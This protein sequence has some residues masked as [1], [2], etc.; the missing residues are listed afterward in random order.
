MTTLFDTLT[1]NRYTE[2]KHV[3]T[4]QTGDIS[5]SSFEQSEADIYSGPFEK[6]ELFQIKKWLDRLFSYQ[7]YHPAN[8]Y[9][10]HKTVPS[11]RNIHPVVPFITYRGYTFRYD[12]LSGN[13]FRMG[14]AP[15]TNKAELTIALDIGR[16]CKVYGTFGLA[17]ALM[18]MGHVA[19]EALI[20]CGKHNMDASLSYRFYRRHFRTMYQLPADL[21]MGCRIHINLKNSGKE[22]AVGS[23]KPSRLHK[24]YSYVEE[25]RL[26]GLEDWLLHLDQ[27]EPEQMMK[28]LIPASLTLASSFLRGSA[29]T[30]EGLVDIGISIE[31]SWLD[32]FLLLC[33][34]LLSSRQLCNSFSIYLF[35]NHQQNVRNGC[36]KVSSK[37]VGFQA[38]H[39]KGDDFLYDSQ[40]FFNLEQSA[41]SCLFTY[42]KGE[43]KSEYEH[44]YYAHVVCA[45]LAQY[46]ISFLTGNEWY[47]RPIKNFH[48]CRIQETLRLSE[49]ER[50]MYMLLAGRS[51]ASCKRL[52][53]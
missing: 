14:R 34:Q 42:E 12:V 4:F 45:E 51:T 28:P 11:A 50:P 24:K 26:L 43:E 35:I 44:I 30:Y 7:S 6:E 19:A 27:D 3:L 32:E 8:P 49:Q 25:L 1:V 21:L 9:K 33:K 5:A 16:S 15:L 13:L 23:I 31:P 29:Q 48:D 38:L 46:T 52:F 22:A 2:N 20:E 37:G 40:P 47:T 53:I 41:F 36:Y 17:L 10:F 18:D 39:V